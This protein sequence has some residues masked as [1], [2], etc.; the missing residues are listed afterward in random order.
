MR[1]GIFLYTFAFVFFGLVQP[2]TVWSEEPGLS[3]ETRGGCCYSSGPEIKQILKNADR[4]YAQFKAKEAAVELNKVLRLDP[5]NFEAIVKLCRVHIDI[6]YMIPESV[7][8]WKP[9]RMKEYRAA[10]EYARTAVNL[11]P[12]ST[13]GYFYIA[14][15]V[16]NL[17]ILS[18]ISKQLEMAE[19]IRGAVEK[20]IV[21]DPKN[22]FAY[23]VYGVW[24]RKMAEIGK[25]RRVFASLVY[26][27][28]VPFGTFEKSIEY[29]KK[30]VA[31]N[32]TVIASRLE[33]A[34]SYMSMENWSS[35]RTLLNSIRNLPLQFSDDSKHKQE[36]EQ[37]LEEIKQ[38]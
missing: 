8:D 11:N 38:K 14:A 4:L 26:G 27:R 20:A 29:L 23:H 21:L 25:T 15:S 6:G 36:A 28:S 12:N 9:Q 32:P 35:A 1:L 3:G 7:Q 5:Q 22:G 34:K 2:K 33:L 18:P 19:E 10:E 17:A 16:G 24:E 31:L 30:A 37:I 13:W